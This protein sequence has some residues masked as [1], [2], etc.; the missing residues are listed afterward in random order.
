MRYFYARQVIS[1]YQRS[2]HW[3]I[4]RPSIQMGYRV[5]GNRFLQLRQIHFCAC[6]PSTASTVDYRW[7]VHDIWHVWLLRIPM[8]PICF[9]VAKWGL[10][11]PYPVWHCLCYMSDFPSVTLLCELTNCRRCSEVDNIHKFMLIKSGCLSWIC[12]WRGTAFVVC[13]Y[14]LLIPSQWRLKTSHSTHFIL[15][16]FSVLLTFLA[17]ATS[18]FQMAGPDNEKRT[19]IQWTEADL[20][21]GRRPR[22]TLQRSNSNLSIHSVHSRRSI[23]PSAALPIQYRT[24]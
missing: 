4:Q 5:L 7:Q 6:G 20:E 8:G 16:L 2:I 21:D 24:V 9:C 18:I 1:I 14:K 12:S 23:D 17:S 3:S 13:E 22:Q 15:P 11:Q 19:T 10:Y